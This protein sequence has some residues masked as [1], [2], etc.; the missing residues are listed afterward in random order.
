[1]YLDV[2][3]MY[4]KMYCILDSFGI[5]VK[6]MYSMGSLEVQQDLMGIRSDVSCVPVQWLRQCLG[7]CH[8]ASDISEPRRGIGDP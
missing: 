1:M 2:S 5:R 8:G 4:P 3:D 7:V 6:Y